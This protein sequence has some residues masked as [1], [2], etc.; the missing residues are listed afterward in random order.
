MNSFLVCLFFFL[1]QTPDLETSFSSLAKVKKP[2][3]RGKCSP[4]VNKMKSPSDARAMKCVAKS[5]HH[6]PPKRLLIIAFTPKLLNSHPTLTLTDTEK[7]NSQ[8]LVMG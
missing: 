3:K 6:S 2:S 4:E 1:P 5:A 7:D 8:A